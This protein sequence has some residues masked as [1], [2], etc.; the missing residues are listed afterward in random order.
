MQIRAATVSE[1]QMCE[2]M[3][4]ERGVLVAEDVRKP[5]AILV[6]EEEGSIY[7]IL[8]LSEQE[9]GFYAQN[10]EVE[11]YRGRATIMG[12]RAARFAQEF[13][14]DVSK[15]FRKTVYC[16]VDHTNTRH[17]TALKQK[18]WTQR[19]VLM[20]LEGYDSPGSTVSTRPNS[21]RPAI[22]R[23]RPAGGFSP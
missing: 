12:M 21:N 22:R 8:Y 11:N 13:L 10:F 17:L 23:S 16:I 9:N 2:W 14:L 3:R 6:I 19:G 4:Q 5:T 7:G 15:G 20:G 1:A 18:G